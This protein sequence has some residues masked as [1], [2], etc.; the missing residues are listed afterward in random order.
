MVRGRDHESE[1]D[2]HVEE[3]DEVVPVVVVASDTE[4]F[5]DAVVDLA[6][7]DLN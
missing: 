5:V 1:A 4:H 3:A 2:N 6:S 7:S